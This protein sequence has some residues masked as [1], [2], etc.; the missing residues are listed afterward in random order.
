M[1]GWEDRETVP[2][3]HITLMI[4]DAHAAAQVL[5]DSILLLDRY[6]LS[7]TALLKLDEPDVDGRHQVA[8]VTKAKANCTAYGLPQ[9]KPGRGRPSKKG[10]AIRLMNL[11]ESEAAAFREADMILYGKEE[12]VKYH[13]VDLLW[14]QKL[15]QKLRFVLVEYKGIRSILAS[16]DLSL[17]PM[18][19]I[20]LYGFRQK[21]ECTFREMKQQTGGFCY[22]FWTKSM[23]K[24]N[25]YLRKDAPHP[26]EA[27]TKKRA[28][29]NILSAVRATECHLMLSVIAMGIVQMVS[30]KF[31]GELNVSGFRYLRTPSGSVVSE[32][33]IMCY[34][35]KYI[36]RILAENPRLS[37]T[38]IIR[39]K[40]KKASIFNHQQAS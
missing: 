9:K 20:R 16:T 6:Y 30:M 26:L 15:Y 5:G 29:Q 38:R 24:L 12:Q 33:T 27:V 10:Q 7:V 25:R 13:S 35:R 1:A 28:K 36:F 37:V 18:Q 3:S 19:I 2:A 14:G 32:A 23:P 11:F 31:S 8:I 21:I 4:E 40:Q 17:E 22:H 39:D 34:F